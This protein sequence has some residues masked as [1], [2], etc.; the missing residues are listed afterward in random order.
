MEVQALPIGSLF[1]TNILI[2]NRIDL[3]AEDNKLC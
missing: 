2:E 3:Q 1:R